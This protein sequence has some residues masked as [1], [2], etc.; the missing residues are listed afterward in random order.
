MLVDPRVS[1]ISGSFYV[2]ANYFF[3]SQLKCIDG[4]A[5]YNNILYWKELVKHNHCTIKMFVRFELNLLLKS[6]IKSWFSCR[7]IVFLKVYWIMFMGN[8]MN[9]KD[10]EQNKN[11]EMQRRY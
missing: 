1:K 3:E 11:E 7:N 9:F 2:W 10:I 6:K 5:L 4:I 8:L